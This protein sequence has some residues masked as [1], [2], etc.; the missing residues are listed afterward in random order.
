MESSWVDG[1]IFR[2]LNPVLGNNLIEKVH[3]SKYEIGQ[4]IIRLGK[5]YYWSKIMGVQ[6]SIE[7][8]VKRLSGWVKWLRKYTEGKDIQRE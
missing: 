5:E 1:K 8:A 4:T 3:I 6:C 7:N 2:T